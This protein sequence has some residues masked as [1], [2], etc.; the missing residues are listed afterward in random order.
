MRLIIYLIVIA[1]LVGANGSQPKQLVDDTSQ[2]S[3]AADPLQ[4]PTATTTA[5]PLPS[6]CRR[7][8]PPGQSEVACCITGYVFFDGQP[9]L[10][11]EVQIVVKSRPHD[12]VTLITQQGLDGEPSPYYQVNLTAPPL[13]VD[14]GDSIIVTARF[15]GYERSIEHQVLPGGQQMDI[16][17]PHQ[18]AGDFAYKGQIWKQGDKG[19]LNRPYGAAVDEDG[20][21]Y[22]VDT[23]NARIQVFNPSGSVI[24]Q[25]GTLG[26]QPRQF[27]HPQD[28][29]IDR[30]GNVY[31]ADTYNH[32]IQKF[33]ST[34]FWITS[35]GGRGNG[36]GQFERPSGLAIDS[37]GSIFVTDF[38]NGRVQKFDSAGV[39][40]KNFGTKG[41]GVGEL[42]APRGVALDRAGNL[43]VTDWANDRVVSW[44]G[45]GSYRT[46]WG[47]QGR[48]NGEF[49]GPT[50]IAVDQN[51]Q[52]FVADSRQDRVQIFT[53]SGTFVD[54][55]G[56][57]GASNAQLA[58]PEG[59]AFDMDNYLLVADSHNDRVL[60]LQTDG[61]WDA[62]IG[63]TGRANGQLRALESVAVDSA[64][65]IFVADTENHR[66]QQFSS[67]G[68]YITSWGGLGSAP[69]QFNSPRGIVVDRTGTIYVAD[70]FN[71]RIQKLSNLQSGGSWHIIHTG[72]IRFFLP[73]GIA[74]DNAGA[75]YVADTFNHRIV[76]VTASGQIEG[77]WGSL[78][79]GPEQLSHPNQIALDAAGTL[80]IADTDNHRIQRLRDGRFLSPLGEFGHADGK[81]LSPEGVAVD[82]NGDVFVADTYNY[83]I[84]KFS[85]TG[86]WLA[87]WG[88]EG[89]GSAEFE[90][91][92]GIAVGGG[93]IHIADAD[94]NRVQT[95][96]QISVGVPVATIVHVN[97]TSFEARDRLEAYGHGQNSDGQSAIVEYRWIID[98][99]PP[100]STSAT[101]SYV[102]GQIGRGTHQLSLAVRDSS[103]QWSQPVTVQIY[104][105]APTQTPWTMLLYLVGDYHDR[106]SQLSAFNRTLNMLSRSFHNSAVRIA[107]QIDGPANGDTRR[108]LMS[109]S[110]REQPPQVIEL[111]Y[112]EQAM[113]KAATLADFLQWGQANFPAQHYYLAIAD[114][115]QAIQ[116]IAWDTTSDLSD[117]SINDNAF[118]KPKELGAALRAPNVAPIDIVHLDACS[119]NLLEIAYELRNQAGVMIASQYLGW[120]Y[121][122]YDEYQDVMDA[123]TSVQDVA[124]G[125]V[126]RYSAKA[127]ADGYPYT[128][129]ALDMARAD[130]TLASV[131][132]MGAELASQV[133]N[134]SALRHTISDVRQASQKFESNGDFVINELDLYV[135]LLDWS[136]R[137]E[138]SVP[139]VKPWADALQNEINGSNPFVIANT[140]KAES[141]NLPLQY[142]NGAYINVDQAHG[143][144]IFYPGQQNLVVFDNYINDRI[145]SFTAN[146][147]WPDFLI[148]GVGVIP[149]PVL[150]PPPGPLAPLGRPQGSVFLPWATR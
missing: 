114:H 82:G 60:R 140:N 56:S 116:G 52:V 47:V 49:I 9:I 44:S 67:T 103:G 119:M 105:G 132:R 6:N 28:I 148:A 149:A 2:K 4:A 127:H 58:W 14:V 71:N 84:Q 27:A 135:D 31:V 118:M 29:A 22:V 125:I 50:G 89:S 147:R 102:A 30:T 112:A 136:Q 23:N 113:E 43:Y 83:R 65:N 96:G 93:K 7:V 10:G 133:Q 88:R 141:R 76:K 54:T 16:V 100:I 68:Q 107:I 87:T 66:I 109:P 150:A 21:I 91:P 61:T 57:F 40:Q 59:L 117:G 63:S 115:G 35:W 90:R 137:V 106:G 25:W 64:G 123:T 94:N 80:Y 146:S 41:N 5:E 72:I 101:L 98:N 26:N 24:G 73:Q 142:A 110:I 75:M 46:M 111:P 33:S 18:A 143:L 138:V 38:G 92:V 124:Q 79:N 39:W 70:T 17:L 20:N 99:G 131:D 78:G 19:K 85:N 8:T 81:L 145:F 130:S 34:G 42:G 97:A 69:G 74:V 121:F 144:S 122:A 62:T 48:D 95:F 86:T 104:V 15:S 13:N 134:N 77:P 11:A 1:A 55:F 126:T 129:A 32:R 36:D 120:S 12:Q 51:N 53:S 139:A 37:S 128:I 108:I 3:L 45:D